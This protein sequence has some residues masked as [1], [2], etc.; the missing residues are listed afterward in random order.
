MARQWDGWQ[1][2]NGHDWRDHKNRW[3]G[4]RG[5][6]D[7]GWR[8]S[9]GGGSVRGAAD[10]RWNASDDQQKAN[11]KDECPWDACI[12]STQGNTSWSLP[13]AQRS[14]EVDQTNFTLHRVAK[15]LTIIVSTSVGE[16][17]PSTKTVV[18][19]LESIQ[20]NVAFHHCRKLLV[21]DSV[22]TQDEMDAMK[23]DQK[24]WRD[25][26]RGH[27]WQAMWN[28]KRQDYQEYCEKLKQMKTE[29][30][31]ALYKVDLVF[32][33][34][35]GHLFGTVKEAFSHVKTRFVF[36][37]Q[38]DLRLNGTFVAADVQNVLDQIHHGKAKYVVLNRDA[39]NAV[40]CK[41]YFDMVP[42]EDINDKQSASNGFAM[43][44]M[45]GYSDQS[46]FA[47]T[48]WYR[49]HVI[50]AIVDKPTCMEHVLHDP[51]KKAEEFKG[52]FLY[53]GPNEGPYV[54]DLIHGVQVEAEGRMV[55]LPPQPARR[56]V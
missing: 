4:W 17:T 37:H 39:N 38:H 46:H 3:H 54:L 34:R 53:G 42:S 12:A 21:F 35:F 14:L 48:D 23:V 33:K 9:A 25:V 2:W 7:L 26:V 52:T 50:D 55:H 10:D 41:T 30:H 27:K 28:R 1:G 47:E 56:A 31:P 24:L 45:A 36:L 20:R 29:G 43:T 8:G 32:L 49:R 40:R 44:A 13:P 51:W 15:E 6:Q 18:E 19:A 11:G 16:W 5:G 22:P